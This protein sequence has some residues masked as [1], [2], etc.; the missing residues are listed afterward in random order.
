MALP[1]ITVNPV[2]VMM[3]KPDN[4]LGT[5]PGPEPIPHTSCSVP[6]Q[7][8]SDIGIPPQPHV[9]YLGQ[10]VVFIHGPW[11]SYRGL[12]KTEYN[13]RYQVELDAPRGRIEVCTA[14]EL[15]LWR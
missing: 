2:N 9:S 8:P 14:N 5:L 12:L 4:V 6:Q 1:Q 10:Q 13:G 7:Q 3:Y 15:G 11:K